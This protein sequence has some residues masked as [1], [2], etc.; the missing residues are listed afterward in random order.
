MNNNRYIK[1]FKLLL[2]M[3]LDRFEL[4]SLTENK[5]VNALLERSSKKIDTAHN[6]T[7]QAL[8]ILEK[9]N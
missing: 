7:S 1:E 3:A 8:R 2:D 5:K 4:I 6:L 9:N